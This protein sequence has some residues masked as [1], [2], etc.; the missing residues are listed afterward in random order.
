M[1]AIDAANVVMENTVALGDME[2]DDVRNVDPLN[3]RL[4]I[5]Y[6]TK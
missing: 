2:K 3:H 1:K 6:F 4:P 5:R